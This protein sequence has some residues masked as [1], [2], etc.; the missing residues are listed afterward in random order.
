MQKGLQSCILNAN[1]KFAANIIVLSDCQAALAIINGKQT[2]TC[3][4]EI[5]EIRVIEREW[6]RRERLAHMKAGKIF[7]QWI[8]SHSD[9]KANNEADLL[10]KA[11]AQNSYLF[12]LSERPSFA[13][14]TSTVTSLRKVLLDTW[15]L[16]H[17]PKSYHELG[18]QVGILGKCP[19]ELTLARKALHCLISTRSGHGDFK[20]YHQ[21]FKHAR[22]RKCTCGKTKIPTH[23][24]FCRLTRSSV[25]KKIGKRKPHEAINW[26]LGTVEGA[27]AF[28]SIINLFQIGLSN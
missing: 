21:R 6:N 9:I 24:F 14:I 15:W 12:D 8:P 16:S 4:R 1:L 2:K 7:A 25:K 3:R 22:Y 26:M 23:F 11:G 19:K 20:E 17:G 18:I 28:G 5:E 27:L 13:T 10:A